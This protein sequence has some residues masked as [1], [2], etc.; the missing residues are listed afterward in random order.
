MASWGEVG[1]SYSWDAL[2]GLVQGQPCNVVIQLACVE[3]HNGS[4]L[5][6]IFPNNVNVR[7]A[8]LMN[9]RRRHMPFHWLM[10][11]MLESIGSLPS[12]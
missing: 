3:P 11:S 10:L 12:R 7:V 1:P 5:G 8:G 2:Q 6:V 4:A 9:I